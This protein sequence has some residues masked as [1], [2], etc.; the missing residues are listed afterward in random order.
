[1]AGGKKD[2]INELSQKML[3]GW[4]LLAESCS[5]GCNVPLVENK[6]QHKIVCVSCDRQ[7]QREGSDVTPIPQESIAPI[8][9]N[10][11]PTDNT[12]KA[13][14]NE[15]MD[16]FDGDDYEDDDDDYTPPTDEEQAKHEERRKRNEKASVEIGV[17]LLAGWTMLDLHCPNPS[18]RTVLMRDKQHQK[19]CLACGTMV[20]TQEEFDAAKHVSL[21]STSTPTSTPSTTLS[22]LPEYQKKAPPAQTQPQ[23]IEPWRPPTQ[24]L[25]PLQSPQVKTVNTVGQALQNSNQISSHQ[26]G[27]PVFAQPIT[28]PTQN[29]I[30][31]N[32]LQTLYQ[33]LNEY[34]RV[35]SITGGILIVMM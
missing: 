19:W 12:P 8:V 26:Y 34:T 16:V 14:T 23:K 15:P 33:K 22:S 35:L 6:K 32:S 9:V 1:M 10:A 25:P 11:E 13:T 7:F 5:L 2:P 30:I 17:K 21:L 3:A 4:T 20:V 27:P 29:Q 24:I 28:Y 18:C 31:E